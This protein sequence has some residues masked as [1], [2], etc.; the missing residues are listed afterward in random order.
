MFVAMLF[1][2]PSPSLAMNELDLR[3]SHSHLAGPLA[4]LISACEKANSCDLSLQV[5]SLHLNKVKTP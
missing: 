5:P 3:H 2:P 1:N 4:F